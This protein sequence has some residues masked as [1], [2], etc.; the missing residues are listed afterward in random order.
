[1]S[2]SLVRRWASSFSVLCLSPGDGAAGG[3]GDQQRYRPAE[4]GGGHAPSP[5]V[6]L[7]RHPAARS[8]ECDETWIHQLLNLCSNMITEKKVF[9]V[10]EF[11]TSFWGIQNTED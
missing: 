10:F 8:D 5:G 9:E 4:P 3:E 11:P 2:L 6:H 1:M 7:H